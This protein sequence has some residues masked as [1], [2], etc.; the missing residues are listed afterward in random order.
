MLRT[1]STVSIYESGEGLPGGLAEIA[2]I[3][4]YIVER[5]E[6]LPSEMPH[7]LDSTSHSNSSPQ[8]QPR[9]GRKET[10]E[11]RFHIVE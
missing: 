2:P 6:A 7:E 5:D 1:L 8:S 11:K 9:E 3:G 10:R 4:R